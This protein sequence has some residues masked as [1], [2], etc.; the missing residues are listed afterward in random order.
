[1]MENGVGCHQ[2]SA[3]L[4]RA[5]KDAALQTGEEWTRD[6]VVHHLRPDPILLRPEDRAALDSE[7]EEIRSRFGVRIGRT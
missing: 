1:M 5:L 3:A 6:L 7:Y 2:G 4:N